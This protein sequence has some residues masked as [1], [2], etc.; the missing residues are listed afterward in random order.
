[1]II[2]VDSGSASP[3]NNKL[4][5]LV[6]PGSAIVAGFENYPDPHRHGQLL[7]TPRT[8]RLDLADWQAIAGVDPKRNYQ[9]F[10][11]VTASGYRE[12]LLTEHMV[13]VAGRF[14][15]ERIFKASEMNG[16]ERSQF[17]GEPVMLIR[18]FA[19]EQG[20]MTDLRWLII[21]ENRIGLLGTPLIVQRALRR[22]TDHADID[23]P[24]MERLSQLR[25]DVSS[26]NVIVSA[27]KPDEKVIVRSASPWNRLLLDSEVLMV[28][29]RFGQKVR[30]DFS[31]FAD[32]KHGAEFLS[33]KAEFFAE[34]FKDD[35]PRDLRKW[36]MANVQF[37][38]GRVQG[39]IEMPKKQFE[40]WSEQASL[41]PGTRSLEQR[42]LSRG[43]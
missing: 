31:V 34:V 38:A 13:L 28:A 7:L 16:A 20:Q 2:S 11:E 29:A 22:Y 8:N 30:I 43:E 10:I 32:G 3:L 40:M 14:D 5:A 6:P 18:P 37:E 17:D 15:R 42:P 36:R 4:L 9:E 26:W 41:R 12:G 25:R 35:V 19:R 21:L 33:Q 39:S 23:M 27:P 1:M 24:L